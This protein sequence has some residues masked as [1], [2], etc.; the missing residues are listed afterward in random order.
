LYTIILTESMYLIWLL[1]CKWRMDKGSD[2]ASLHSTAEITRRWRARI[3]RRIKLD[4]AMATRKAHKWKKLSRS[5][6]E[7]TWHG[8]LDNEDGLPQDWVGACGVLVGTGVEAR[9][10]GRNR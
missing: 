2:P 7:R 4:Q 3:N 10:P 6:V 5:L 1:R 8:T 9:P